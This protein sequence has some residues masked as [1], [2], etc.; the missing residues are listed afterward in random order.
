MRTGSIQ[1]FLTILQY[2]LNGGIM[3]DRWKRASVSVSGSNEMGLDSM[4]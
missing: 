4:L 3:F 1:K 2:S